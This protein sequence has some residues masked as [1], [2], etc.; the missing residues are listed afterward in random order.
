[1]KKILFI[2]HTL[3]TGGGSEKVLALLINQLSQYYHITVIE[4][5]EDIYPY[6]LP[7]NVTK[8]PSMS[9]TKECLLKSQQRN[10]LFNTLMRRLLSIMTYLFPTLVYKYF[11]KGSYDIEIS[12]NYLYPSLLVAKSLNKKSKKIMWVH[13][14]IEDL[15]YNQYTVLKRILYYLYYKMQ[16]RAFDKANAIIPISNNTLFSIQK[17]YPQ[18]AD[19]ISLINNGYDFSEIKIKSEV[20]QIEKSN[21]YRLISVGRLDE[22]KNPLLQLKALKKLLN[23]DVKVELLM[24]GEGELNTAIEKEIQILELENH[25]K[26]LGYIS[27]PY[28]YIKSANV[29]L[30]SSFSEGFPTVAVEALALGIPV[31][32]TQVGGVKEVIVDG[33][34]GCIVSSYDE[35]EYTEAIEKVINFST[36]KKTIEQSVA[37]LTKE[38]W[39]RNVIQLIESN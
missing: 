35:N 5:L 10:Y 12:F 37:H 26:L 20:F 29:L 22:N 2:P 4:R 39:T 36:D 27:N 34:N 3:S 32:S 1:M 14:S 30:I 24:L 6:Q 17:L 21:I 15:D 9:F 28:P 8:L 11:I 7:E 33:L 23:K 19:K 38:N 25:V 13:G 31:V 16:G 18:F